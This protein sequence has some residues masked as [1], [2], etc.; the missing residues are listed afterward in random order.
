MKDRFT[1]DSKTNR[2]RIR[3]RDR[4]TIFERDNRT[5]QFCGRKLEEGD[6]TIDHIIPLA[7]GGVDEITNFVTACEDCN[8]AKADLPL[9]EFAETIA[10]DVSK[11]PITGDPIIDNEA[12]PLK[13][14]ILRKRIYDKARSEESQIKGKRFQNKIEQSFR[15]AFWNTE[16]GKQLESEFPNLPGQARIMVPEIR[17]IS[18]TR[19][20]ALLLIELAKSAQTR[21]LIGDVLTD[22]VDVEKVLND[23]RSKTKDVALA[24]R[25]DRALAR[26]PK[27]L[28][29]E[30]AAGDD[31]GLVP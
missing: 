4:T 26:L 22:G 29:T 12:L 30:K 1:R 31:A 3:K 10:I 17:A 21:N 27:Q 2:S 13:L 7:R 11:L 5:C 28:R 9:A 8:G 15:R 20:E 18:S 24:K 23:L 25:I 6:A 19:R 16:E 14:R